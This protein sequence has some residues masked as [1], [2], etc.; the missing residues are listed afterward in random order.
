MSKTRRGKAAQLST[1]LAKKT[2]RTALAAQLAIQILITVNTIVQ[3]FSGNN[4]AG[5]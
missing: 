4:G 2:S 1:A 5:C 3:V